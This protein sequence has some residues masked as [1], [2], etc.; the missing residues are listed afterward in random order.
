MHSAKG[1]LPVFCTPTAPLLALVTP[2]V[3]AMSFQGPALRSDSAAQSS[4]AQLPS[5]SI[6]V[7]WFSQAHRAGPPWN[8]FLGVTTKLAWEVSSK[9]ESGK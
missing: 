3:T 6:S 9:M 7:E 4:A 1:H 8:T 5:P 2:F